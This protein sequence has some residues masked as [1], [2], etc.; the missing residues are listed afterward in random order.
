[1]P[2]IPKTESNPDPF[3]N[4]ALRF[5]VIN[6]YNNEFKFQSKTFQ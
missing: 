2:V 1:L 3:V 4:Q 5:I 6:I